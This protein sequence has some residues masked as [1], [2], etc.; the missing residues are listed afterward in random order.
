MTNVANETKNTA[1]VMMETISNC[2]TR[3]YKM[4]PQSSRRRHLSETQ[5]TTCGSRLNQML[6]RF[7]L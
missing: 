2:E 3:D 1:V 6:K 5:G 7:D 4:L